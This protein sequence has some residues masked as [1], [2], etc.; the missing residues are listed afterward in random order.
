MSQ[1]EEL[2]LRDSIK[3]LTSFI[4]EFEQ[5][6]PD[7]KQKTNKT[8]S[9]LVK[10]NTEGSGFVEPMIDTIA[11]TLLQTQIPSDDGK[12]H[13][14]VLKLSQS[15]VEKSGE[16]KNLQPEV[17]AK[18]QTAV[19]EVQASPTPPDGEKQSQAAI[20]NPQSEFEKTTDT[21]VEKSGEKAETGDHF[22]EI[23]M[24]RDYELEGLS[25]RMRSR[26]MRKS[27]KSTSS[28]RCVLF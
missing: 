7:L 13:Y 25:M 9:P 4:D 22:A 8:S 16:K 27:R 10:K 12:K 11:E 21:E 28:S 6:M 3:D 18:Q 5:K 17:E 2:S 23:E 20:K 26:R 15:E 1:E 24:P 19:S 14:N